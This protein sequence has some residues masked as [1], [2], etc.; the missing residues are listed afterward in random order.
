MSSKPRLLR[1]TTVPIS[2]KLLLR[3][4]LTFFQHQGFE[5]LAVSADGPEVTSL[6]EEGIPHQVIP[7]TRKIT[8]LRDLVCLIRLIRI[9][10][11]FKPDIVHT[12]TPKAGLLGMLAAKICSV[13]VR[14]HTVAG[15]PLM[16]TSGILRMILIATEKITYGCASRVYSNSIGLK[17]FIETEVSPAKNIHIIGKGSSN[18]IDSVYFSITPEL[19]QR[20]SDLRQRYGIAEETILFCFVGRIVGDKGVNELMIA[21]D[22]ISREIPSKLLLVGPFEDDLDPVSD[23]GKKILRENTNVIPLGYQHDVRPAFL[24]S[25]IF[26]LPSYREGFPNVVMQACCMERPCIVSDINGCNEIIKHEQTGILVKPKDSKALYGAMEKLAAD[27]ALRADFGLRAR[28][29]VTSNFDQP[30]VWEALLKEYR[31]LLPA[32]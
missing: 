11:K 21:F 17:Q 31:E 15:L 26:V 22:H 6:K 29:F 3:G 5:V 18:G 9:I 7:M 16:E 28:Q 4:Q 20:A 23:A 27:S 24:A 2:L 1:V 8:P 25:D 32:R 19:R 13:P 30:F 10:K 14:L 12:H